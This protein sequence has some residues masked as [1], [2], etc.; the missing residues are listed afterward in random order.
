MSVTPLP[1]DRAMTAHHT[2]RHLR[3]VDGIRDDGLLTDD[4]FVRRQTDL[5]SHLA[6]EVG[7]AD[8]LWSLDTEPLPDEPF[9]WTVVESADR[10]VVEDVLRLV[11]E[12]CALTLDDEYR[13]VARRLLARVVS[14]DPRPLRRSRTPTRTAAAIVWL[15]GQASGGFARRGRRSAAWIWDWFGVGSCADRGRT[16]WRAAGFGDPDDPY[17]HTRDPL[18]FGDAALLPSRQR[19]FLLT[20]RGYLEEIALQRRT[21]AFE[22]SDGRTAQVRLRTRET[23]AVRVMKG[24]HD[25]GRAIVIVGFGEEMD[26]AEY[27][28]LSVP[29]AHDLV[30]LLQ[31]ALE[32]PVPG[33]NAW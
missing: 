2:P 20:R 1:H 18:V 30:H 19:A 33:L 10:P 5:F 29:D 32:A 13:T 6:E 17:D 15:A 3:A 28:S 22:N 25:D 23:R 16:L 24:R 4:E 27:L 7:G 26:D 14:R 31:H 9:D 8:A 11:D 12:C 21:I